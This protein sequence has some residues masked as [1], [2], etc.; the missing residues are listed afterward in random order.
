MSKE[1][2]K[3]DTSPDI[4]PE[5]LEKAIEKYQ[6]QEVIRILKGGVLNDLNDKK[7]AELC[8]R[9]AGLRSMEIIDFLSRQKN[10]FSAEMLELDFDVFQNRNFVCDVLEKYEKKFDTSDEEECKKLFTLACA[11]NAEKT[12]KSLIRQKKAINC[13]PLIGTASLQVF[14]QISLIAGGQM[15]D[16]DRVQLYLNAFLSDEWE[17]KLIFMLENKIDYSLKNTDGKTAADLLEERVN[18]YKYPNSKKGNLQKIQE[19][20]ALK[21]LKKIQYEKEHPAESKKPS[22]KKLILTAIICIAAAALIGTVA[23]RAYVRNHASTESE[24]LSAEE[25]SDSSDDLSAE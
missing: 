17:Q 1:K 2:T 11:V 14:E 16:N 18:T 21:R 20:Q 10:T 5:N 8:H 24:D 13:Y 9:L 12:V 23:G 19:E 22:V 3:T 7:R 6:R 15:H 25:E 4:T